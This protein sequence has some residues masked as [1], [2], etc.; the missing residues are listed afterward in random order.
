MK[1]ANRGAALGYAVAI[2]AVIAVFCAVILTVAALSTHYAD[3]YSDYA[4]RKLFLDEI[5]DSAAQRYAQSDPPHPFER[6]EEHGG[7]TYLLKDDGAGT[8]TVQ[9]G[10]RTVLTIIYT[11]AEGA[12]R[13]TQYV[14][15]A[16]PGARNTKCNG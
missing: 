13:L 1:K 3:S 11:Q 2:M 12:W 4:S 16:A 10:S 6:A 8:V 7:I 9:D 15:G 5:G 14:Y